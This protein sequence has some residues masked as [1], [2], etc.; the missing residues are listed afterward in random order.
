[1]LDIDKVSKT[2]CA[3]DGQEGWKDQDSN[4]YA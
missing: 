3:E 2:M 4:K 1:M